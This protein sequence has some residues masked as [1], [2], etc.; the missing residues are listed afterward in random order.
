[1]AKFYYNGVLLPEI[2]QDVLTQYP[3]CLIRDDT[4]SGFY[5]LF[6]YEYDFTYFRNKLYIAGGGTKLPWY[7]IAKATADVVEEWTYYQNGAGGISV[8]TSQP[9]VWSNHN[10]VHDGEST[11]YFAGTEAIP[12][13]VTYYQIKEETLTSFGDQARRINGTTDKLTTAQMLEIFE[14][15]GQGGSG[16]D[17]ELAVSLIER[18][19]TEISSDLVT[20][21]GSYAFAYN[22]NITTV[23]FPNCLTVG[24]SAF[25]N[26]TN[27]KSVSFPNC[28]K[29]YNYA[30]VPCTLETADFPACTYLYNSA[31]QGCDS[32]MTAS[33]ENCSYVG[34]ATFDG[35]SALTTISIPNCQ[36]VN[37]YAFR[38]CHALQ[39]IS[40]P[41]C[42]SILSWAFYRCS[43][44][45]NVY[46]SDCKYISGSAFQSCSALMNLTIAGSSV[47]SLN[48]YTVFNNTPL[49]N[50]TYTGSF[51]SIY[52]PASLV[53]SYKSASGWKNYSARI[54]A[55][56]E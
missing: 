46:L 49:S 33:F 12:Q 5:D 3:K 45:S 53:D 42:T 16:E 25:Y 40:I 14:G 23:N 22:N 24:S 21:V 52:V 8:G 31:F 51:G 28:T 30:F 32:L 50:S 43:S 4:T 39:S 34:N 20:K 9:I 56:E 19:V 26:C 44:L 36:S 1:M 6:C 48:T 47:T 41:L 7:R 15:A 10:V 38:S 17:G 13:N 55:I 18:T 11:V 35:C 37:A 29:I 54:T 2:P 27:L